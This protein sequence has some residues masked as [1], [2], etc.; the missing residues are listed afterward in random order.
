[1]KHLAIALGALLIAFCGV[2]GAKAQTQVQPNY[3]SPP[4]VS[5]GPVNK[6]P[7]DTT[8]GLPV[9]CILGCSGGGGGGSVTQGTSPWVDNITQW[10]TTTLGAPTAWGIAPSGNVIGVNANILAPVGQ[11]LSAASIPVVL[12]AAQ[13]IANATPGSPNTT[14]VLSVQGETGMTPVVTTSPTTGGGFPN[15]ATAITATGTGT[16][17][18]TTATLAA[19]TSKFTYICGFTIS[20][21]ATTAV[22]GAATVTGTVTGSLNYIQNVGA[23]TAA[24]VLTQTFTPCIPSSAV[25]TAI[26]VT[27][28]AAGIAGNTAVNAWGYQQ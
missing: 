26:V 11:A 28:A 9:N 3:G 27:S 23:A 24:G 2:D 10:A 12:P 5:G 18:S 4:T 17:A 8:H 7:V 1:M 15:A 16:T 19:A 13:I 25:N 14:T 20:A 6:I 21:D 22:A